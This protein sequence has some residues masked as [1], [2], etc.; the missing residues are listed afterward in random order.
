[1]RLGAIFIAV[2]MVLIAA[3]AG[4]VVYLVFGFNISEAV[5]VAVA[6]LT[7][8]GLYNTVSTR[9]GVRAVVGSQLR[10]LARGSA[11][12]ARQVAEMGR[13]LA[14]LESRVETT[15]DKTRAATDPLAVEIGELG[16]LVK[17]LAETVAA[18]ETAIA[19]IHARPVSSPL[20]AVEA[21]AADLSKAAAPAASTPPATAATAAPEP[22]GPKGRTADDMLGLIGGAIEANRVDLYL[23][24]IVT[25]PQRKVRYYEAMSRLRSE[26][27]EVLQAADFIAQAEAGGMM[28]KIDKLVLFRC[29]QV[30]RRLL[31]KNREIGLFCNLSGATLTDAGVFPQ[32]LEFMEANRA[33]AP[34]IALEFTQSALRSAGPIE[35]ESLA[36]LATLGFRFSLDNLTDLRIE[37]RELATRGFRFVK[38]PGNLLLNRTGTVSGDIHHADLSDLLG[39]FGIDLIAEKIESEGMV[40]DLLDYDVR[41]GQGFLFSPPRPVRAEALQGVADRDVVAREVPVADE[42]ALAGVSV[43]AADEVTEAGNGKRTTGLAQLARGVTGRA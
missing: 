29:V 19:D 11:D 31:L 1:M 22:G 5:T 25:L 18:H 17:Q 34:S 28:P 7:A 16:T 8:L 36:A 21:A 12:M 38:V 37:P 41:Y 24:P 2:C 23:Q 26:A 14:A 20:A 33:I 40:V 43:R 4:A 30:V 9:V 13:R 42:G 15:L 39:R 35:N 3:S 6:V 32:L 10:D 27:G